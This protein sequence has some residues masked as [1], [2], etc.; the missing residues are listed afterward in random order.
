MKPEFEYIVKAELEPGEK[1]VWEGRSDAQVLRSSLLA[2]TVLW[3]SGLFMFGAGLL[4]SAPDDF[5][6]LFGLIFILVIIA[7]AGSVEIVLVP[8]RANQTI[9][10][11]TN[12]RVLTLCAVK[13]MAG[14]DDDFSSLPQKTIRKTNKNSAT[15]FL[16]TNLPA[17]I[18]FFI[19]A[20][21]IVISFTK[22]F[23]IFM[24]LGFTLTTIGWMQPWFQDLRLPLPRFRDAP[25]VFYEVGEYFVF[26]ESVMLSDIASVFY[27][28]SRN[29]TV[30]CFVVS[31][32]D[33]CL[34][35]RAIRDAESVQALLREKS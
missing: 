29:D 34:R 3:M 9:Y 4:R 20:R 26:S 13:R 5:Q 18:F 28:P 8:R 6:A 25:R 12:K 16:L 21:D 1:V 22:S 17:Q 32:N 31:H 30:N 10:L 24:L 33:G 23:D 11:I 15:F 7:V 2:S 14:S 27:R 19:L 35:L